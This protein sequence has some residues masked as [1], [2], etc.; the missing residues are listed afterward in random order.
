MEFFGENEGWFLAVK[1]YMM[2]LAH[3]PT[4][5]KYLQNIFKISLKKTN[6]FVIEG[7]IYVGPFPKI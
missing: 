2:V 4:K 3:Y 7:K 6:F 1:K 5:I